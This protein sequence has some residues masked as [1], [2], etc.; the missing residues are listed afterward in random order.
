MGVVSIAMTI[1]VLLAWLV[2]L[3]IGVKLLRGPQRTGGIV[4]TVLGIV[5]GIPSLALLVVGAVYFGSMRSAFEVKDFD[6]TTYRGVTGVLHTSYRGPGKL[7]A[8]ASGQKQSTRY[9]STTG[10]FTL[11]IG[12]YR[13]T[14]LE[15][16]A[17]GADGK[18]W[19][20][21]SKLPQPKS[22]Q[23]VAQAPVELQVGPPYQAAIKVQGT[24]AATRLAMQLRDSGGND[25]S[26]TRGGDRPPA[27]Q[28]QILDKAGKVLFTGKFAY[29]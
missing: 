13:L 4:L 9:V 14:T 10:D 3:T 17:K 21:T 15:V 26:L 5:W 27:P 18:E 23:I 16:T 20:A 6:P 1:G 7:L 8:V 28:F 29:G 25:V 22:V 24:G 19:G 11:P 12:Q 2:P